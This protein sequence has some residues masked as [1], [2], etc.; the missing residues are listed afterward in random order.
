MKVTFIGTGTAVQGVQSCVL[1]EGKDTKIVVD[2]G[3]GSLQRLNYKD[4]DAI[5][6]THNHS[7]HNADLIPI[8]K[9]R[10]LMGCDPIEVYGVE[11]TK[12]FVESALEAYAYLRKKL[13]FK[14]HEK[15]DFK[16]GEFEVRA[17][18]TVHSI[19]SQAYLI[20]DE[21]SSVLISGDTKPLKEV[22]GVECDL[23]IHEMSLPFGY[24]TD[25]HTTPENFAEVLEFCKARKVYFTHL[26]PMALDVADEII[27]FLRKRSN[28]TF[29]VAR[30]F[31][32]VKI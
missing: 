9:A 2:V 27:D 15:T 12:A 30:D 6:I 18:P 17:I 32:V 11:G 4:L 14:V 1:I 16:V 25:D 3:A 28:V 31:D 8:L 13:R 21:N 10:W 29:A 19:A 22:V 26:Y 7:D 23:L 20:S 5:L 24:K